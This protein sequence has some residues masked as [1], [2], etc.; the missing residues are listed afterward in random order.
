MLALYSYQCLWCFCF[1]GFL[2]WV[3]NKYHQCRYIFCP[4]LYRYTACPNL[5]WRCRCNICHVNK[6]ICTELISCKAEG[7]PVGFLTRESE[8]M[9]VCVCV[10]ERNREQELIHQT[11]II[12]VVSLLTGLRWL[13]LGQC[14]SGLILHPGDSPDN[15]TDILSHSHS[16]GG[17]Q[18]LPRD[19]GPLH[20][21]AGGGAWER[22]TGGGMEELK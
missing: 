22:A 6:T 17:G 4:S 15:S 16:C 7:L 2:I 18:P 12:S 3:S 20:W 9:C 21:G 1:L 8:N 5:F 11:Q 13:C 10:R 14:C 19:R